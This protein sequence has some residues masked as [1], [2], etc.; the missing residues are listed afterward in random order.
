MGAGEQRKR[1]DD[2][3]RGAVYPPLDRDERRAE[4]D[5]RGDEDPREEPREPE[6]LEDLGHLLEEVGPLDFLLGRAPRHV[7][8]EQ[9][10]EDRLRHRDRQAAEE[11][12]AARGRGT[13]PSVPVRVRLPDRSGGRDGREGKYSQERNP[14][15]VLP[16]RAQDRRLAEPVLEQG[17]ADVAGAVEDDGAG[18]PDLETVHV[19]AVDGELEAQQDVVHDRDR[20]AGRD[21]VCGRGRGKRARPGREEWRW[22]DSQYENM[23]ASI[24]NL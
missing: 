8:R 24:E 23:Y 22:E 21:T 2:R 1:E 19:E 13:P 9:V 15:D 6:A 20:Y 5:H 11:E 10:R 17:E 18:E 3:P 14:H 16:E 7:V 4:D 12:E